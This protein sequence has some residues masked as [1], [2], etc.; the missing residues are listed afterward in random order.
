MVS[1]LRSAAR[2]GSPS[3]R[4]ILVWMFAVAWLSTVTQAKDQPLTAIELYDGPKGAAYV[5]LT[6]VL[7][8][9]KAELRSCG[10]SQ[11]IDKS[12]YGKL[13]KVSMAGAQSL[14]RRSDGTLVLV[15]GG[16][17]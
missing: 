7:I 4:H 1:R 8:N 13:A 17:A 3:P 6:D 2:F 9:G 5:Q 14:E 11:L 12:T 16:N 10:T 15:Q